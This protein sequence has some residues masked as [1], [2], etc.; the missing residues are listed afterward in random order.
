MNEVEAKLLRRIGHLI[1]NDWS[2][3]AFDGRNVLDW[4][5]QVIE[6]KFD[7]LDKELKEYEEDY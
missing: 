5:E 3:Y 2:G 1:R 4:I 7:E 6:G